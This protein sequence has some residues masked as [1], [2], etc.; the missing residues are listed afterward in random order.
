M[1]LNYCQLENNTRLPQW[2]L[3]T[4]YGDENG[5]FYDPSSQQPLKPLQRE[6][7]KCAEMRELLMTN[8]GDGSMLATMPQSV[9]KAVWTYIEA[10]WKHGML[11]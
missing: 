6:M 4:F 7:K 8:G 9:R 1:K 5:L 10:M 11:N 3:A 2:L